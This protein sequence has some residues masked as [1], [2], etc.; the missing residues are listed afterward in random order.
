MGDRMKKL[1]PLVLTAAIVGTAVSLVF[2]TFGD[3]NDTADAT[4]VYV[5]TPGAIGP[6]SFAP[7]DARN[8]S[9]DDSD[10]HLRREH[11]EHFGKGDERELG[12]IRGPVPNYVRRI[13]QRLRYQGLGERR[14]NHGQRVAL[15]LLTR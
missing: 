3:R 15:R 9:H 14:F 8:A 11:G 6:D 7:T 12:S 4:T 13:E 5:A 1:L 2:I 10:L